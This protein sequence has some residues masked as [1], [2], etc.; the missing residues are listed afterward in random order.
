M[1]VLKTKIMTNSR[2]RPIKI[3]RY[4]IKYTEE[5]VYLRKQI[6]LSE[7]SNGNEV[8]REVNIN[9]KKNWAQK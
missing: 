3:D 7:N 2:E 1:N 5:Y 6:S 4:T 9:W 8:A